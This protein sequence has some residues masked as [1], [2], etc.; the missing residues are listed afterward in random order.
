MEAFEQRI[1]DIRSEYDSKMSDFKAAKEAEIRALQENN[2]AAI[3]NARKEQEQLIAELAALKSTYDTTTQQLNELRQSI[4]NNTMLL[5]QQQQQRDA[6]AEQIKTI[7]EQ[8]KTTTA[9]PSTPDRFGSSIYVILD[10]DAWMETGTLRAL[11]MTN[12]SITTSP[13]QF[14]DLRQTWLS[15][16]RGK[17]RSLDG[18]GEY[19]ETSE[20]CLVPR[21]KMETSSTWMFTRLA[22]SRYHFS[23]MSND[24]GRRLEP[25]VSDSV[26][27]TA[28]KE[29]E[30]GWFIVPVG[31]SVV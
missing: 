14:K 4:Q 15:S 29:S 8:Q 27:L 3:E 24:C 30:G 17:L 9:A 23:I 18:S 5:E 6:L 16:T 7:E 21:G 25:N 20:N 10:A 11:T 22:K 1:E 12:G 19:I 28:S 31:T 13:F 2:A 26:V